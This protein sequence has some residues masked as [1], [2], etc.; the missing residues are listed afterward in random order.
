MNAQTDTTAM[1]DPDSSGADSRALDE[2]TSPFDAPRGHRRRGLRRVL[3]IILPLATL[4]TV[5]FATRG[6]GET[7]ASAAGHDHGAAPPTASP[8]P[9]MLSSD[10]A[11]RIGVTYAVATVTP[12]TRE[13]RT[14]GQV[15]FDETRV[16]TISPKIDGW[17][18]RLHLD[19]TGQFV[20]AGTPL[21]ALYSPMLV[22]AQEELLLA[23]RL[24]A[25]VAE[26][27]EDARRSAQELL[28]SARRR[29]GY[30]DIPAS[31]VAH[32]E[33]A[34]EVQRALTLYAPVGGFVIEKNV[35]QGQRIMAGDALY[36]VADLT[37]VWVEGEVFEQDLSSVRLGV[38]AVAELEALPGE[39]FLG[40][41]TYVYPTL[42]P[43][44]RTVR[45]RVEVP[46]S[47]LR[48]KPG[49]YA[50]LRLTGA[51]NAPALSVPRTAVLSTGERHLVFLKRPD[52]MLEPRLVEIGVA[53]ADRIEVLRG[54]VAGDT[55]VASATFLVDAESNLGT[56]LG[57]MGS[58]PG[59]DITAPMR[60]GTSPRPE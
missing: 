57:G 13:I 50:T 22:A 49:M 28:T 12:L 11:R 36:K 14:V 8:Q 3:Y 56:V 25:D 7:A 18:E 53:T 38:R 2:D 23:R 32:I 19:F 54:V 4:A 26:G 17:V 60:P 47:G 48:L 24:S 39:K 30:W 9:V 59:M 29:L 27:S 1:R 34:G 41:I 52:G 44:T 43:D 51:R 45:V 6:P 20:V 10:E 46:N 21:L 35:L 33:R 31:D 55:V 5:Y 15:T 58:M 16:R 42:D 37:T 40:R